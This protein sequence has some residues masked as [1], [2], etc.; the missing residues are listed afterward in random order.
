M[1]LGKRVPAAA[2]VA[3][4]GLASSAP[5][6]SVGVSTGYNYSVYFDNLMSLDS[7]LLFD[8]EMLPL[9]QLN[10]MVR[11]DLGPFAAIDVLESSGAMTGEQAVYELSGGSLGLIWE[12]EYAHDDVQSQLLFTG[13]EGNA[14]VTNR[15]A[16]HSLATFDLGPIHSEDIWTTS[17]QTR[18]RL[19]RRDA[20]LTFR[21]DMSAKFAWLLG[22]RHEWVDASYTGRI[23]TLASTNLFNAVY[24]LVGVPLV[25]DVGRFE[26]STRGDMKMRLRTGRVGL[27]SMVGGERHRFFLA[28]FLQY[29]RVPKITARAVLT[30]DD[31]NVR[32]IPLTLESKPQESAGVDLS[33]GYSLHFIPDHFALELRYRTMAYFPVSKGTDWDDPRVNH[34]LYAGITAWFGN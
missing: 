22:V 11:N 8:P 18:T 9:D 14:D 26:G 17:Q 34:G 13:L 12:G 19:Q 28:G 10:E 16:I 4:F 32:P 5:A 7:N 30:P 29:S 31:A 23:Q 24:S 25:F 3:S 2:L 6:W 21:H 1:L 33:V 27:Q 20:E 15:V